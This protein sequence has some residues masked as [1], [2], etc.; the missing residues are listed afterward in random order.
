MFFLG[1]FRCLKGHMFMFSPEER[2]AGFRFCWSFLCT[3]TS[4]CKWSQNDRLIG[5]K[6]A[7]KNHR[8]PTNLQR[9]L[10]MTLR[11]MFRAVRVDGLTLMGARGLN[12]GRL[13]WAVWIAGWGMSHMSYT[14]SLH[15]FFMWKRMEK[16]SYDLHRNPD[17][18]WS[19]SKGPVAPLQC[20]GKYC[21]AS[22]PWPD[23]CGCDILSDHY[24][25]K[26]SLRRWLVACFFIGKSQN[27][28]GP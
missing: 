18:G 7:G 15:W 20:W 21:F 19:T 12:W 9:W 6:I 5:R 22:W 16:C 2:M 17:A 8:K 13:W 25:S 14:S 26:N 24:D 23:P 11:F 4:T 10:P 3:S 28:G 27:Q 1:L